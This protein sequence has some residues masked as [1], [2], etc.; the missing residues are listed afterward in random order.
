MEFRVLRYFLNVSEK[1]KQQERYNALKI[2]I[3]TKTKH[4]QGLFNQ[5]AA[6]M[7]ATGSGQNIFSQ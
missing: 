4:F 6:D 5:A 7:F 2:R 1:E 3:G